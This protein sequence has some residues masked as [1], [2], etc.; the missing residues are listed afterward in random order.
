METAYYTSMDS[1]V[2]RLTVCCTDKGLLRVD[3][4]AGAL[5]DGGRQRFRW[6]ASQEKTRAARRELE[7]YFAGR[8]RKF[9]MPLDLR[10]TP[11]Q[12][13]VWRALRGIPYGQ[14]RSYSDIAR[15]V[16]RPRAFRAVGQANHRN[17]MAI[18]VPCHRVVAADGSLGGY[19]GGLK[20]KQFLLDLEKRT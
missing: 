4:G 19:G 5:H 2:G 20:M 13:K 6:V 18:V 10:G 17:P 12:L 11:F 16:G 14:T 9:M 3:C 15:K 8:L 1:P 7:A